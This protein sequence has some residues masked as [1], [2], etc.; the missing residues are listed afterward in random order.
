[1][2]TALRIALGGLLAVSS[3]MDIRERYIYAEPFWIFA[4]VCLAARFA[5]YET[6]EA[7]VFLAAGAVPGAAALILSRIS[8]SLGEGDAWCILAAG[9]CCGL[10]ETVLM[11]ITALLAV[12]IVF[13]PYVVVRRKGR[14]FKVPFVPF[15]FGA[16]VLICAG[17]VLYAE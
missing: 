8:G 11:C 3:A 14:G 15:L 5:V 4:A 2:M 9:L 1:M 7:G 13:L 10:E 16:F 17:G 6:G 12:C